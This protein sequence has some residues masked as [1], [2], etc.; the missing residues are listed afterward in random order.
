LQK[1]FQE[2]KN[3]LAERDLRL[4]SQR[5][6]ILTILLEKADKHLSADDIYLLT[7]EHYPEIGI[8]TIYRTLE[9]FA[10]L[11]IVHKMEFGD[12]CSRYEF[13]I[14][15]KR[16]SHHHLICQSCGVIIEFNDDLLEEVEEIIA[17]ESKFKITDH[18]LRFYGCCEKCQNKA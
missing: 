16:H 5:Q 4:T 12:G 8:A 3:L 17:R 14:G 15:E 18:C 11:G 10:D 6:A 9:L 13:N 7:K 2:M 1:I